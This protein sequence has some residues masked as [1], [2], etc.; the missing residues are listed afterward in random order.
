MH[1][2]PDRARMPLNPCELEIDLFCRGLRVPGDVSLEGARGIRRTRAGLGSGLE[3]TIP[4]GSWLK[5]AIWMNAPVVE[6][7]VRT[8]PYL[9]AGHPGAYEILDQRTDYK[10]AVDIPREPNWYRRLTSFEVPMSQIGV[11]QGTYLGI[12]INPIC[13]FWSSGLN[14]RFCTTGQNVGG[15]EAAAKKVED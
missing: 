7:F 5:P 9:L 12:Y 14:C 4:T 11:L 2:A 3:L 8:S 6:P 1:V 15:V 13:E 10:Y